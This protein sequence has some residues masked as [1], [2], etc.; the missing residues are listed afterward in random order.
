MDFW[1][2]ELLSKEQ[3]RATSKLENKEREAAV[4]F[5][6]SNTAK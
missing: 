5:L 1:G 2:G 3:R 4:I 6:N